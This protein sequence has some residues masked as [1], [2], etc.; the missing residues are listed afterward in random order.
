MENSLY[1]YYST[2]HYISHCFEKD[3]DIHIFNSPQI[4]LN[5]WGGPP[6][7]T[8]D[9]KLE[10][11][12]SC[13]LNVIPTIVNLI[14]ER[15]RCLRWVRKWSNLSDTPDNFVKGLPGKS[16]SCEFEGT[17]RDIYTRLCSE[18]EYE[19]LLTRYLAYQLL[20]N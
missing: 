5:L 11:L 8:Y 1:K 10:Y 13:D 6:I 9:F 14:E 3:F 19:I 15:D 17:L 2:R 16:D 12:G 18:P 20:E 4:S 7:S